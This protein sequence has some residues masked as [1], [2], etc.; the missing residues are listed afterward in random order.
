MQ[1][2]NKYKFNNN[3]FLTSSLLLD[4]STWLALFVFSF[5]NVW[6]WQNCRCWIQKCQLDAAR[7]HISVFTLIE[8][9]YLLILFIFIYLSTYLWMRSSVLTLMNFLMA[10]SIAFS[11]SGVFFKAFKKDLKTL[12]LLSF[13]SICIHCE[14][15]SWRLRRSSLACCSR[16]ATIFLKRAITPTTIITK[17]WH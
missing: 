6:K 12:F 11:S 13:K 8:Q 9:V 14:C 17:K 7:W 3:W 16:T 2:I 5:S 1:T 15:S 4:H 10:L